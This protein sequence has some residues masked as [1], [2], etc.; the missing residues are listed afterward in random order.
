MGV[1]GPSPQEP[2]DQVMR[3]EGPV[4]DLVLLTLNINSWFPFRDRWSAEGAPPEL[5]SATVLLLQEHK[6][7]TT[8]LCDDAVE[9][10]GRRGW[11]AVFRPAAV[12]PSGKASGGVAILLA[13]RAD[14]GVTDPLLKA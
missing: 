7:T 8:A 5:Q 9:W 4:P 14:I 3:R 11:N 2:S 1:G 13:Q 10:C 6:L 12:L